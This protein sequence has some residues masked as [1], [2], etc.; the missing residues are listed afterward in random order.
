MFL[1]R[2]G[3]NLLPRKLTPELIM[4]VLAGCLGGCGL[5]QPAAPPQPVTLVVSTFSATPHS[6][7]QEK[8][9]KGGLIIS[10]AAANEAPQI[11]DDVRLAS[12]FTPDPG[13]VTAY[14][15]Q[16]TTP[17]V[18]PG[19]DRVKFL[20]TINNQMARVF[21]GSGIVVQCNVAN[22]LV[23]VDRSGYAE[24][25]EAMIPGGSEQQITILGPK[26]SEIPDK[27]LMGIFLFDVVTSQNTAGEV[28]EKQN[29][30]WYY[31]FSTGKKSVEAHPQQI[32]TLRVT[33]QEYDRMREDGRLR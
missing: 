24:L 32:V 29:F 4:A 9:A 20:V 21:H 2:T 22:H 28:T 6:G 26:F 16:I 25:Q 12:A 19:Q 3:R 1:Q 18:A 11:K 17:V 27:G 13:D 7:T 8:Q 31:D 33:H 23:P 5:L 15:N 30:E 14:V 10:L